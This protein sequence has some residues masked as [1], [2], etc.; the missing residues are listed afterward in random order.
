MF[1]R[2]VLYGELKFIMFVKFVSKEFYQ[3]KKTP[4][5]NKYLYNFIKLLQRGKY[6][7]YIN[8]V[9]YIFPLLQTNTSNGR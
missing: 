4:S 3:R 2:E 8:D 1:Y 5:K 7:V 9:H 6:R